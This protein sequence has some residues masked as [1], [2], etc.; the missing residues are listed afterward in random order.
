MLAGAASSEG[1]KRRVTFKKVSSQ[2][3]Q[4]ICALVLYHMACPAGEPGFFYMA[5]GL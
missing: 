1:F 5:A 2:G 3:W 4:S